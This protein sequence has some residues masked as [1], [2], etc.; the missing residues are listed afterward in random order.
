MW[1]GRNV[2][3]PNRC[4][5]DSL[6]ITSLDGDIMSPLIV[7]EVIARPGVV[8]LTG[9]RCFAGL[10]PLDVAMLVATSTNNASPEVSEPNSVYGCGR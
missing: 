7:S 4:G 3:P 10:V 5:R 8:L 9:E 6:A 2:V 1:G